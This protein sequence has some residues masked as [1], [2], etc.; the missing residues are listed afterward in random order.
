MATRLPTSGSEFQ[1]DIAGDAGVAIAIPCRFD[2]C[3]QPSNGRERAQSP[4]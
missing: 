4:R 3:I 1:V 2:D